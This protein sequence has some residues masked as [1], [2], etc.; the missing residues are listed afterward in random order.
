MSLPGDIPGRESLGVLLGEIEKN[1][2]FII[3]V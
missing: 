3:Q 1:K 2:G